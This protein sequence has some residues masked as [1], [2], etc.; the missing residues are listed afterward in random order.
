M[1]WTCSSCSFVHETRGKR[2]KCPNCQTYKGDKRNVAILVL[3]PS[4]ADNR[5]TSKMHRGAGY[6][7]HQTKVRTNRDG[8]AWG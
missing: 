8:T 7:E 5:P 1:R 6:R 2:P 3:P 4:S